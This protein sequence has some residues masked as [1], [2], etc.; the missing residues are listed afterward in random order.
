MGSLVVHYEM[1]VRFRPTLH[2]Y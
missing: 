1:Q 2:D